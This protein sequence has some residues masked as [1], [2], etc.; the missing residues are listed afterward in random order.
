VAAITAW[1]IG[2]ARERGRELRLLLL[3]MAVGA[4]FETL[5]AQA[6][7]L[8]SAAGIWIAGTAPI[9]M[10]ALWANFATTLNVSLRLL[11]DRPAL[12]ALLGAIGAPVAY[13][14]GSRLGAIEITEIT[15]ALAAIAAGWLFLTP[16]L[17]MAAR[18]LDGYALR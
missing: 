15:P 3:A 18:R 5:L 8:K 16:L 7:W 12:A 1:H 4:L 2:N 17:F 9:W 11:R 6:G 14:G 13:L 10:V